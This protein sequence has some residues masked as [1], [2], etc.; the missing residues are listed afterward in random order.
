MKQQNPSVHASLVI[1]AQTAV[2]LW[3]MR[4]AAALATVAWSPVATLALLAL[5]GGLAWAYSRRPIPGLSV[6]FT[7]LIM[8]D[9]AMRLLFIVVSTMGIVMSPWFA[10]AAGLGGMAAG[11]RFRPQLRLS[12]LA[13]RSTPA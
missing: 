3:L 5:S 9:L 12:L 13:D 10:I 2:G 6:A 11:L 7:C 8:A 1:A 4:D